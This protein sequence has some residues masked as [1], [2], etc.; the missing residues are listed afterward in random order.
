M[1]KIEFTPEALAKAFSKQMRATLTADQLRD[2]NERNALSTSEHACESHDYCDS[3]QVMLD[4]LE[5][6]GIDVEND[7][8]A[9]D[10]VFS[11]EGMGLLNKAWNIA[12]AAGFAMTEEG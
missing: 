8:A 10:M 2:V 6:L 12:K 4:A 7:P 5:I 3:N 9:W 1:I 11:D